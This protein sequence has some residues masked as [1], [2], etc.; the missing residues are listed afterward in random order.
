MEGSGGT[1]SAS[2]QIVENVGQGPVYTMN[3]GVFLLK[4]RQRK[5]F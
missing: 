1:E 5:S 4:E 2:W 3:V